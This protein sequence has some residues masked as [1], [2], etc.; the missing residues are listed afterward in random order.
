MMPAADDEI[1]PLGQRLI[2]SRL[3]RSACHVIATAVHSH[4][5]TLNQRQLCIRGGILSTIGVNIMESFF[6]HLFKINIPVG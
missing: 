5:Y 3:P 2:N 1:L 4:F 6:P